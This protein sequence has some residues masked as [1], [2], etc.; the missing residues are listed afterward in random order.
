[1][2]SRGLVL[3]IR[4]TTGVREA[5]IGFARW[6]QQLEDMV[7]FLES[8]L[9][10]FEAHSDRVFDTEGKAGS[11]KWAP[12]SPVTEEIRSQLGFSGLPILQN[13]GSLRDAL[14][15]T[16]NRFALRLV[17]RDGFL[18]GTNGLHYA[19]FHQT[20]TRQKG[21]TEKQ[22]TFLRVAYGI[23]MRLGHVIMMP[24]RPPMDLAGK[25]GKS[26][27]AGLHPALRKE[28]IAAARAHL[29]GTAAKSGAPVLTSKS[30]AFAEFSRIGETRGFE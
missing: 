27:I 24:A 12:L 19:S 20:G 18:Y 14:G 5:R 8:V 28:I 6:A 13:T 22:Q 26:G 4:G 17:T 15:R 1:M 2:A 30:R 3:Q 29:V 7:P 11:G 23:H 10:A 21:V 16:R 25:A 9:A